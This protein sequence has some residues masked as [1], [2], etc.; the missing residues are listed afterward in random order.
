MVVIIPQIPGCIIILLDDSGGITSYENE[1]IVRTSQQATSFFSF[2][3][4]CLLKDQIKSNGL[5]FILYIL[6]LLLIS[7]ILFLLIKYI[8]YLIHRF[9]GLSK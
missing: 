6:N 9:K 8:R 5:A 2:P 3:L 1:T 7:L 4:F